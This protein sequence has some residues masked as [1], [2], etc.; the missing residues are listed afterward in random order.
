MYHKEPLLFKTQY[1]RYNYCK[2]INKDCCKNNN[3]VM[4]L[5]KG[6]KL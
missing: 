2:G 1:L 4:D 6:G 3:N 5:N